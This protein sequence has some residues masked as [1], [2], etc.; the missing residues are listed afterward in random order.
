[1]TI[2][3]GQ[4]DPKQTSIIASNQGAIHSTGQLAGLVVSLGE[5][6]QLSLCLQPSHA[7]DPLSDEP[8]EPSELLELLAAPLRL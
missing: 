3:V 8:D 7:E 2:A 1:L 4:A 5:L 6:L